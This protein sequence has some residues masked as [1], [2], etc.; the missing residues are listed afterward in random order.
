MIDRVT[1]KR[2]ASSSRSRSASS[3][4]S[5]GLLDGS[6]GFGGE[7]SA[8]A[9]FAR[10]DGGVWT[11]DKDGFMPCLLAAE[12]TARTGRDPGEAYRGLVQEFGEPFYDRVE[13]PPRPA[14]KAALAK[15]SPEQ[16]K[17]HRP[18]GRPDTGRSSRAPRATARHRRAEGGDRERLVRRAPVRHRGHLQD[19]RRELPRKTHLRRI[20]E[21]AQV[22]ATRRPSGAAS[23]IGGGE[24]GGSENHE[25]T[26]T[27]PR[28]AGP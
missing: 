18:G 9:T 16:V 21:E 20:L 1:A 26:P 5:A 8:G 11:T 25:R 6:I 17:A 24:R 14:Q 4:S 27:S 28:H 3:G 12:M 23:D 2:A 19:I 22:D 13:A 10:L 15:L 7:E